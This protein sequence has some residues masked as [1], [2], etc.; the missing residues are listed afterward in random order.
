MLIETDELE[1]T[2]FIISTNQ[3]MYNVRDYQFSFWDAQIW[4]T[5]KLNQ[6]PVV[7]TEDFI[8]GAAIEGVCFV[9]PLQASEDSA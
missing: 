7:Y 9:N 4:A 6:I 1:S 2:N 3:V 5:A 8:V